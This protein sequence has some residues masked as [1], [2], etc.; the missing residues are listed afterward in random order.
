M[1][2]DKNF[3]FLATSGCN[4]PFCGSGSCDLFYTA[5]WR[6]HCRTSNQCAKLWWQIFAQNSDWWTVKHLGSQRRQRFVQ[7]CSCWIWRKLQICEFLNQTMITWDVQI[8]V[9]WILVCFNLLFFVFSFVFKE[10]G[11]DCS[12][13]DCYFC[14]ACFDNLKSFGH[15]GPL[16]SE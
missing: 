5:T 11:N 1:W 12:W 9:F 3:S 6:L 15:Q 8:K 10:V 16:T 7:K 2:L 4:Q 14:E 13:P